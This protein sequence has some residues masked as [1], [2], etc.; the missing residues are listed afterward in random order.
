MTGYV[1]EGS[2]SMELCNHNL[3]MEMF[4]SYFPTVNMNNEYKINGNKMSLPIPKMK[5]KNSPTYTSQ[6]LFSPVYDR[7]MILH[8]PKM[9]MFGLDNYDAN[10]V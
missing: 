5:V 2:F 3:G 10:R 9:C 8:F 7:F 1:S 4:P 6:G